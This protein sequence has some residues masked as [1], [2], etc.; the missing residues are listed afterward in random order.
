MVQH[1]FISFGLI[2][3]CSL[4]MNKLCIISL[5]LVVLA[6]T[7]IAEDVQNSSESSISADDKKVKGILSL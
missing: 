7:S 4:K 5:G 2:F 1:R 3:S 6:I